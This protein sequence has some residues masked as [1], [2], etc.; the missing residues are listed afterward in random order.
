MEFTKADMDNDGQ[1]ELLVETSGIGGNHPPQMAY[2]IKNRKIIASVE[3]LVGHVFPAKN[4]NGFYLKEGNFDTDSLCC[5]T[6]YR[7]YRIVYE[8]NKFIPVW[9]QDG[10]YLQF[11]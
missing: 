9:Q 10:S 2:V 5:A 6:K 4:G 7:L 11:R 1:K 3:I 8:N